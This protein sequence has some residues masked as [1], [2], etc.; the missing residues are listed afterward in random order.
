MEADRK[1]NYLFYFTF[2][3]LGIKPLAL[4]LLDKHINPE[5]PLVITSTFKAQ[6]NKMY[7]CGPSLGVGEGHTGCFFCK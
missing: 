4:P 2:T 3:F 6:L 1:H 7:Q 5:P